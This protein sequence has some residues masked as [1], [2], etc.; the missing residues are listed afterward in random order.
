MKI[1]G[2]SGLGA[3][4]RVFSFLNLD[5]EIIAVD[6]IKP[7]Q[8]ESLK[9]YSKRLSSVINNEE[10]FCIIGVSFGG[11]VATEISKILKPKMTILVS[12]VHT[13]NEMRTIYRVLGKFKII[14]LLPKFLFNPPKGIASYLFGAQ[15]KVLLN[16]ILDD[17]D[18]YFAKWAVNE[19]LTWDNT[20]NLE[21][22]VKINGTHD[23][24]I[25]PRG[26]T[27]MK[28][29]HKGTHFMIVD[30]ANEVSELIHNIIYNK[31]Y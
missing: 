20:S 18:L 24:L 19:L 6:W 4:K 5:D 23:K 29:I 14:P 1:Y 31:R 12:S 21:N 3:D 11:L 25:P 28:C 8:K 9:N 13:K 30:H 17:T 7:K 10:D 26:S 22:V 16:E 2:I 27:K 15:N